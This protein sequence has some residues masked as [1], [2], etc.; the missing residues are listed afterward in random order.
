MRADG[1]RFGELIPSRPFEPVAVVNS[2]R[3]TACRGGIEMKL[4]TCKAITRRE[5]RASECDSGVSRFSNTGFSA[6][7]LGDAGPRRKKEDT[8]NVP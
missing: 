6:F 2:N 3:A 5:F 1:E 8:G 7:A 4:Q